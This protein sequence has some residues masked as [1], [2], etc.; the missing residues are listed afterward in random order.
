MQYPVWV[1]HK[2]CCPRFAGG[3]E[4]ATPAAQY[5]CR[6]YPLNQVRF[7]F[8]RA[9][10]LRSASEARAGNWKKAGIRTFLDERDIPLDAYGDLQRRS[11]AVGSSWF[12]S[13]PSHFQNH[14]CV[15]GFRL[16]LPHYEVIVAQALNT[17]L[18]S[19]RETISAPELRAVPP[20]TR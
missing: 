2:F 6:S 14:W 10:E 16:A 17:L 9:K 7:Y 13:M 19:C 1:G 15:C 8:L 20:L 4:H 18:R 11:W 5:S 3:R 12:L